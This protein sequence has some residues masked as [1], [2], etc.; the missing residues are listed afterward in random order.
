MSCPQGSDIKQLKG[1]MTDQEATAAS[2]ISAVRLA[3]RRLSRVF[4][5]RSFQKN[6]AGRALAETAEVEDKHV[7]TEVGVLAGFWLEDANE[8]LE[9]KIY[10]CGVLADQA[11][12]SGDDENP[13][14]PGGRGVNA[15]A[16]CS[17]NRKD[18]AC[19]ECDG[20]E[21]AD[22]SCNKCEP[23]DGAG[24]IVFLT[25]A[26]ILCPTSYYFV[27]SKLTARMST[28]TV[29]V[30]GFGSLVT[31]VQLTSVMSSMSFSWPESLR[32]L[33]V[34]FSIFA[35]DVRFLRPSCVMDGT[36]FGQYLTKILLVVFVTTRRSPGGPR[37]RPFLR[38]RPCRPP[39]P[40]RAPRTGRAT[41]AV[42]PEERPARGPR[43]PRPESLWVTRCAA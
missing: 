32:G 41:R 1:T 39:E 3:G 23:G 5:D 21:A 18:I 40:R 24:M 9:D 13:T 26:F 19:G 35:F 15:V 8:P 25:L 6:A 28:V 16:S 38:A 31:L 33:F 29:V 4:E 42:T 12:E 11:A 43:G 30:V 27:N 7:G 17:A 37:A 34:I 2:A 22:G 14:C 36:P 20:W 10:L